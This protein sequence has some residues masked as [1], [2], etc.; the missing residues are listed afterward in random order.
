LNPVSVALHCVFHEDILQFLTQARERNAIPSPYLVVRGMEC[1][2]P[3]K[4]VG[5]RWVR[6]YG[7]RVGLC[8]H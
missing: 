3:A 2:K 7:L 8:Q 5:R 4:H 1:R 6:R